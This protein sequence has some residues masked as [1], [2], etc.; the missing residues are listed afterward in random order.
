ML[1]VTDSRE[2]LHEEIVDSL[3]PLNGGFFDIPD[4]SAYATKLVALGK[5]V[6]LRD[7]ANQKLQSYILYYDNGPEVYVSMVWTHPDCRGKGFAGVLIDRLVALSKKDILLEVN[8]ANPAIKLYETKKF[9]F[10][11]MKGH[12]HIMRLSR[13]L[14]V[15]QPYVFPYIGY[16]HLIEAS[17]EIIF[18]DDVNYIKGGWINRNR[19]L[20]EGKELLITVPLK[21]ASSFRTIADTMTNMNDAFRKKLAKQLWAAY[22]KAP[23]YEP[24]SKMVLSVFD[25]ADCSIADLAIDSIIAVYL[26]LGLPV[27]WRRSSTDFSNSKDLKRADRLI[28]LTRALGYSSYINPLGGSD[29]YDKDY[30]SSQGVSLHFVQPE[31]LSYKQ[32]NDT[33]VPWLS[34]ID[35]LMFNDIATVRQWFGKY[36]IS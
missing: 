32:F 8:P 28:H 19:I 20:L 29:L 2:I 23:F 22:G 6:A 24:V 30:F 3:R 26:Y 34:I 10:E 5:C 31:P 25:R 36:K 33:F 17:S 1:P 13:R 12:N 7:V 4:L 14:S 9:R 35:V 27:K 16:F 15:M 18:Y 11:A 21:D